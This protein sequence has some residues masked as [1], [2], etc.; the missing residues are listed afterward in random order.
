M[1][2]TKCYK[3]KLQVEDFYY[4]VIDHRIDIHLKDRPVIK[5]INYKIFAYKQILKELNVEGTHLKAEVNITLSQSEYVM[6]L[7]LGLSDIKDFLNVEIFHMY[8]A[9]LNIKWV[10]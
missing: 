10:E 2:N 8:I 5:K 4:A 7:L 6:D 9:E 1:K 3:Y